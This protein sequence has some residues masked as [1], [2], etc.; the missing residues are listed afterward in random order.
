MSGVVLTAHIKD[1][2]RWE[3]SFRTHSDLFK[4]SKITLI[5]YTIT[6]SNDVVLYS[7]TDDVDAYKRMVDSPAVAKAM[8][9]DGVEQDSV[10]VYALDKEFKTS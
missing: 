6:N 3:K 4:D 2:A 5:H 1:P 9:E 8:V 7:E 10:K